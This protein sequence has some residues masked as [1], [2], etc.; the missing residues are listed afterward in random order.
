MV[1]IVSVLFTG[2]LMSILIVYDSQ[3]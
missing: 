3:A 2:Y 1:K